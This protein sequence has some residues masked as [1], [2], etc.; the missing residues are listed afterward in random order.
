MPAGQSCVTIISIG[1]SE[2]NEIVEI[3]KECA[4]LNNRK[5]QSKKFSMHTAK[6]DIKTRNNLI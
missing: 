6:M 4:E 1:G 3:L 5:N 2:A